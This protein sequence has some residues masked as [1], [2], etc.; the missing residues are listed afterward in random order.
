MIVD[1][2]GVPIRPDQVEPEA[3]AKATE[4]NR[5]LARRRLVLNADQLASLVA[6]RARFE[7]DFLPRFQVYF[8][9]IDGVLAGQKI[10]GAM[11]AG[12]CM[13]VRADNF[14]KANDLANAG[15][16]ATVDLLHREYETRSLRGDDFSPVERGL[17]KEVAGT[18]AR[19]GGELKTAPK[20][21]HMIE[22][23]LGGKPWKW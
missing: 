20:L 18:R 11:F 13:L 9:S 1:E 19:P 21:K 14:A 8:F 22:H 23:V 17:A 2:H 12:E 10:T 7:C 3:Q 15:L 6:P 16:R 4:L 5:E